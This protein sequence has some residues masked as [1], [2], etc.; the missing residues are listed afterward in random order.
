MIPSGE[1]GIAAQ[2]KPGY[3]GDAGGDEDE[4]QGED[5]IRMEPAVLLTLAQKDD[6]GRQG[7]GGQ[8]KAY[9]IETGRPLRGGRSP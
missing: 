2:E 8:D 7:R 3:C 6:E 9:E 4:D 5:E 1:E